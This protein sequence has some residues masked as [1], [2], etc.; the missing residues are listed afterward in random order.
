MTTDSESILR[1][2]TP[3]EKGVILTK[4]QLDRNEPLFTKYLNFWILYPDILLDTIQT[5]DDIAH[6]SIKPYQRMILRSY[7]RYRYTFITAT[8]AASKSFCAYLGAYL[9]CVLLPHS[10]IF[11]ASDVKGTVIKTAEAKFEEFFRHWPMLRNELSTQQDDGKKGQKSST[12]YYE[13]NFKNGSKLTVIA[14]DT[15]RG[16]RATSAVIE[17]AMTVDEVSYNE[18]LQPQLN[19]PRRCA[20]GSLNPEEPVST[21]IF[22]TTARERTLFMYNRL[23][24]ITV[25]AA[26]NPQSYIS[27]GFSYE[28]H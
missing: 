1:D 19:T 18:V 17:E 14:K 8:R 4:G 15:S 5:R 2:G 10:N 28:V 7:M 16:L 27:Y 9:K 23:I 6:F 11:I 25:N 22:I 12:S 24:E 26:V 20:D 13:L 21:Q 3:I